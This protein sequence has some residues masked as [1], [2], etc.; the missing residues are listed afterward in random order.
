MAT[1]KDDFVAALLLNKHAELE[2]VQFQA[3]QDVEVMQ[4][5]DRFYLIKDADGH[6]FNV[7]KH[8]LDVV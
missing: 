5:W 3:G 2:Q 6:L 1:V 7:P 4:T 8:N